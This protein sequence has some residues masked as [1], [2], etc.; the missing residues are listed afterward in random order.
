MSFST[1]KSLLQESRVFNAMADELLELNILSAHTHLD[2]EAKHKIKKLFKDLHSASPDLNAIHA[3]IEQL[4]KDLG[5]VHVDKEE[6]E[7]E[8]TE[9]FSASNTSQPFTNDEQDIFAKLLDLNLKLS[10]SENGKEF[11]SELRHLRSQI[12]TVSDEEL[13]AKIEEIESKL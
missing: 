12:G 1:L 2:S 4:K 9:T 8:E 13:L 5:Q 6:E 11:R 3:E 10:Q 7:K